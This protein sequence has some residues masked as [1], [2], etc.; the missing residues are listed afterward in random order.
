MCAKSPSGNTPP[1]GYR[2]GHVYP[3]ALHQEQLGTSKI[4]VQRS[5]KK[6][7]PFETDLMTTTIKVQ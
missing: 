5:G 1:R 3:G 7:L 4:T 2:G 6:P